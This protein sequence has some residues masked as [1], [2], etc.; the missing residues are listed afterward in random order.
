MLKKLLLLLAVCTPA[1]AQSVTGTKVVDGT[2]ALLN[3]GNWCFGGTCFTVTRGNIAPGSSVTAGVATV[4]ITSGSS[5]ILTIPAVTISGAFNWDTFVLGGG[6]S[7]TGIGTP[8]IACAV[9]ATF[10]QTDGGSGWTCASQYGSAVWVTSGGGV[11]S[12]SATYA[13]IGAPTFF[14][15]SP[16]Q[17][18]RSDPINPT[19]AV[20]VTVANPGVV[21]ANWVLQS[22]GPQGSQGE[23]GVAGPPG[24]SLSYPGVTS[25]GAGGLSSARTVVNVKAFG[26]TGNG[27]TDDSACIT[28]AITALDVL[29]A[30]VLYFPVGNYYSATCGFTLPDPTIVKGDGVSD[31]TGATFG[32]M[33]ICGSATAV[34]FTFTAVSGGVEDISCWNKAATS[35]IAGACYFTNSTNVNQRINF[36]NCWVSSFFDDVHIGV[37]SR[38]TMDSCE[39]DNSVRRGIWIQNTVNSDAGDWTITTSEFAAGPRTEATGSAAIYNDSSGGGKLIVDKV[40]A[41]T[42]GNYQY[43]LYFNL[44]GSVQLQIIGVNIETTT[45]EPIYFAQAWPYITIMANMLIAPSG[46]ADITAANGLNNA[47]IGGGTMN[48]LGPQNYAVNLQGTLIDVDVERFTGNGWTVAPTNMATNSSSGNINNTLLNANVFNGLSVTAETGTFTSGIA[49]GGTGGGQAGWS[50]NASAGGSNWSC[51][52]A[53]GTTGNTGLKC[54]NSS[55]AEFDLMDNSTVNTLHGPYAIG[56]VAG[57]TGTKTAGTCVFTMNGGLVMNVTG[58]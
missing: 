11:P 16:C 47:Y 28:A 30:G 14:C 53:G 9:G 58:C 55:G 3:S 32:S 29:G 8:H 57:F 31:P 10:T 51:S 22:T 20:Y 24:G 33:V 43:G 4:T 18:L 46:Y 40:N 41:N 19:N 49:L 35:P 42:G 5:T 48:S 50:G 45:A 6:M 37:G 39:I 21:T 26:C 52:T 23:N 54:V 12:P 56:G 25:D 2:G 44:A 7:A 36:H 13:G 34:M 1:F 27:T 38:W 15:T 17:Y